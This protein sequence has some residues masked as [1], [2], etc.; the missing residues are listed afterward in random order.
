M[1]DDFIATVS[2]AVIAGLVGLI[3]VYLQLR[4]QQGQWVNENILGPLYNFVSKIETPESE[5]RLEEN[6]WNK[7][8]LYD[9]MKVP[10]KVREAVR[11]MA[12]RLQD[13]QTA[14]NNYTE[15][16]YYVA[17]P[18]CAPVSKE[19]LKPLLAPNDTIPL[20]LI[21]RLGGG[22]RS[23]DQIFDSIY[24]HLI[25]HSDN[26]EAA[27]RE[28][29]TSMTPDAWFTAPFVKFLREKS[30][31]TLDKI[32]HVLTTHP[33]SEGAKQLLIVADQKRSDLLGD[34]DSLRRLLERRS[35]V[36]K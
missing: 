28:I 26:S 3:A 33:Q 10:R 25:R 12:A 24:R 32:H 5:E 30:P 35:N 4:W 7:V 17:K 34:A 22:G 8:G 6:P 2:G 11:S 36:R 23:T 27:W 20:D 14:N 1:A 13:Y 18:A 15:Y 19:A 9:R 29:E 31:E 21:G 16:V